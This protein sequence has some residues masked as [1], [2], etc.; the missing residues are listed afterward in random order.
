MEIYYKSRDV[1]LSK[2]I[3]ENSKDKFEYKRNGETLQKFSEI[4]IENIFDEN[5]FKKLI[6]NF[7]SNFVNKSFDNII[8]LAGAGASVVSE[9]GM[10]NESY[11]KTIRMIAELVEQKLSEDEYY[12]LEQLATMSK[13]ENELYKNNKELSNDFNLEDFLSNLMQYEKYV[14]NKK[15]DKFLRSKNKIL[16]IIKESVKYKYNSEVMKHGKLIKIL[17]D[18]IKSP[19][20][21]SVVTTNYDIL[22][23]EAANELNFTVVDGFSFTYNPKFDIDIFEWNLVKNIPNIKTKEVEYKKNIINLLKI[24]GSLTWEIKDEDI[25]RKLQDEI[26]TP[27]MIF[28]SSKKYYQSYQKPYFELF[29]KFQELLKQNN[30]LLITTGF[31]FYD[32]HIAKMITQAI[33]NNSSLSVLITDFNISQE[34]T[35]WKELEKLMIQGYR[36]SFLKATL[37][38]DLTDYLGDENID[39]R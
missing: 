6:K 24:H 16:D 38:E 4:S 39:N 32:N 3:L 9:K 34:H 5:D 35:N 14:E 37:N 31:S 20:K 25:Y 22:F 12:S 21:L 13:F 23:E 26:D 8:V 28:P 11:G 29:S 33:L 7:V 15:K 10:I 18:K 19:N 2:N 17:S 27:V 30:T 36:V 1:K